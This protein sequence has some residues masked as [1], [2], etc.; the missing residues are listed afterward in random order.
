MNFLSIKSYTKLV[1]DNLGYNISEGKMWNILN[2]VTVT[3]LIHKV[4]TKKIPKD[5]FDDLIDKQK[6]DSEQIRTSN[7]YIPTIDIQNAQAIAKKMVQNRVTI[8]GLGYELIYR[9]FGE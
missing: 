1:K 7:V 4:E 9:L 3:E 5:I 6:N 8:S 2:V